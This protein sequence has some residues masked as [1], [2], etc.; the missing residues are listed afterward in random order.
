MQPWIPQTW[1]AWVCIENDR[2]L[3]EQEKGDLRGHEFKLGLCSSKKDL[4]LTINELLYKICFFL[5]FTIV[6]DIP[7]RWVCLYLVNQRHVFTICCSKNMIMPSRPLH[8]R[9]YTQLLARLRSQRMVKSFQNLPCWAA[10]YGCRP[11]LPYCRWLLC[12]NSL[13]QMLPFC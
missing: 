13:A 3:F 2:D 6:L 5:F 10:A 12:P 11:F 1:V 7:F 4:L 8:T 9:V